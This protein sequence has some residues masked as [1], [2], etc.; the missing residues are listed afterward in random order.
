MVCFSPHRKID[1]EI[2]R[3]FCGI[4]VIGAVDCQ[5][6]RQI[7]SVAII[8]I[9]ICNLQ[10]YFALVYGEKAAAVFTAAYAF[11]NVDYRVIC[12]MFA[13]CIIGKGKHIC[14]RVIA[15]FIT[16]AYREGCA[17]F[18]AYALYPVCALEL[19]FAHA[20]LIICI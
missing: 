13:V 14:A 10:H 9:D 6:N 2:F 11:L 8:Y 18:K 7:F 5:S 4:Q 1:K 19:V 12:K 20:D 17:R 15:R 3:F 16:M